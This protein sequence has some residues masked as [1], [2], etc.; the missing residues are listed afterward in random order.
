MSASPNPKRTRLHCAT[1]FKR[2]KRE[3]VAAS[4]WHGATDT[5]EV[6]CMDCWD[7][8]DDIA[9]NQYRMAGFGPR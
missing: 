3:D 5:E 6:W 8:P 2:M 1:C 7:S 4:A 9:L